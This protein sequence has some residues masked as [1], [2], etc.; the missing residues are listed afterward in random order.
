MQEVLANFMVKLGVDHPYHVLYQLLSL[1]N[2]NRDNKGQIDNSGT[3]KGG[4]QQNV[5]VDK[6]QAAA[7][8]IKKV[9]QHPS[10]SILRAQQY[11]AAS[12]TATSLPAMQCILI[13]IVD[14]GITSSDIPICGS[15]YAD[16]LVRSSSIQEHLE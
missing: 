13:H 12:S 14:L 2:G 9:A 3:N 7:S 8:V 11:H 10:R 1:Q 15:I 16:S 5:D 6:I 4:L